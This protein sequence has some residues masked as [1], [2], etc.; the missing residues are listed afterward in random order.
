MSSSGFFLASQEV[1]EILTVGFTRRCHDDEERRS[2]GSGGVRISFTTVRDQ[3]RYYSL[4]SDDVFL[5]TL[6]C[7]FG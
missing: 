2:C 3:T 4:F 7:H 5:K 1:S 6:V